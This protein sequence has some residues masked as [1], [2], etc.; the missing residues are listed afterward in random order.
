MTPTENPMDPVLE[1]AVSEIRNEAISDEMVDAAAARVWARLSASAGQSAV[2]PAEHIRSCS[3]FQSLIPDFRGGRLPEARALLL[4]DHLHEC[5]A[6][7]HVFEGKV[8]SMP[9]PVPRPARRSNS[10][11]R[12]A[13]AA[14]IIV[15]GG[16]VVWFSVIQSGP[17]AGRAMVQA[18]NG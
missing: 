4:R 10:A 5:V 15:A 13:V 6:C 7:R 16:L 12:W 9:A 11:A 3:D 14:G 8:V 1:R 2:T 17:Y 18:V